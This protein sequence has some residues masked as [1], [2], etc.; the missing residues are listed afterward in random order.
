MAKYETN[1]CDA[2]LLLNLIQVTESIS[3]SVVPLAMFRAQ[4]R[5]AKQMY[6]QCGEKFYVTEVVSVMLAK[7]F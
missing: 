6:T 5:E 1:A 2:M 3:W 4:C 7:A